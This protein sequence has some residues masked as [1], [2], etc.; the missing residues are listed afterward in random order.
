MLSLIGLTYKINIEK[1]SPCCVAID[2]MLRIACAGLGEKT[3][4][5]YFTLGVFCDLKFGFWWDRRGCHYVQ[6]KK[7]LIT[8]RKY[9]FKG[10]FRC[11]AACDDLFMDAAAKGSSRHEGVGNICLPVSEPGRSEK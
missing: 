1:F 2:L 6:G 4:R 10:L 9:I 11:W 5:I 3:R 7:G 8:N